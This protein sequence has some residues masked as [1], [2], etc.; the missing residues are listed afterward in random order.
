MSLAESTRDDCNLPDSHVSDVTNVNL[1]EDV[2]RE[3]R[4]RNLLN[5]G[6]RPK[7]GRVPLV[8]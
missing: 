1:A 4:S 6:K 5:G 8:R 7:R 2:I 3:R